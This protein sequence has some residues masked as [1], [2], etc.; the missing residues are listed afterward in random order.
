MK[1]FVEENEKGDF[2]IHSL[3]KKLYPWV[4][5]AKVLYDY[6]LIILFMLIV[7]G[8]RF[9]S[10]IAIFRS[11]VSVILYLNK[12]CSHILDVVTVILGE[13][14]IVSFLSNAFNNS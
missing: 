13:H 14:Q 9:L 5:K 4:E 6:S 3:D 11:I 2:R 7:F 1:A 8:N 12:C 10:C